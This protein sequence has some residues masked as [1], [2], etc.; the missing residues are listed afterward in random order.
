METWSEKIGSTNVYYGQ[1]Q[2]GGGP[3]FNKFNK[4]LLSEYRG[5]GVLELCSGPGFIGYDLLENGIASTVDF[6]DINPEVEKYLELTNKKSTFYTNFIL[7]DT[8]DNIPKYKYDIIIS[9][10][11]HIKYEDQFNN[12]IDKTWSDKKLEYQRRILLDKNFNFHKKF[13]DK[14]DE[15]LEVKG[16][17]VLYE[18]ADYI[19]PEE[20]IRMYS[21]SY[22]HTIFSSMF[23]NEDTD[24]NF[25]ALKSTRF[26]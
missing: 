12:L 18:N 20:L 24:A 1:Y 9:N 2:N 7:S 5:V 17:V 15:Y 10:P 3:F 8:F 13:F 25:Y 16:S 26:K 6:A 4:Q 22:D 21:K 14:V 19:A 23:V 11:P